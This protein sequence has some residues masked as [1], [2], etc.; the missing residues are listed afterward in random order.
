IRRNDSDDTSGDS[1]IRR[2][3]SDDTSGDSCIHRN[4]SDD[5]SGDSC[6]DI[7]DKIENLEFSLS[8]R[9]REVL[10]I[11][12]NRHNNSKHKMEMPPVCM[13]EHGE[14]KNNDLGENI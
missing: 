3:D 8:S 11:Y 7:N 12:L 6:T 5:T 13:V 14:M 9:Q 2:N 4:D 1:C 10:K